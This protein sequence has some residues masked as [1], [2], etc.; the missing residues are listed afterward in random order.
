MSRNLRDGQ[1]FQHFKLAFVETTSCY[2]QVQR[3]KDFCEKKSVK[4]KNYN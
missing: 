4:I 3:I 2:A 1:G